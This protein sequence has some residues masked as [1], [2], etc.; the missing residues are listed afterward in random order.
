MANYNFKD[1]LTLGNEGEKIVIENLLSMGGKLVTTNNDNKY[2]AIIN[3]KGKDISYEI[4]TDVYCIPINDTGNMFVE[5]ECRGKSSGIMV[6]EAKWFVTYYKYLNQIWYIKTNDLMKLIT[7]NQTSIKR[8]AG[9]GDKG[10]N[11]KGFLINRKQ[12]K[13]SFIVVEL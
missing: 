2:D 5:F 13:K 8:T 12:F 10:S 1:D 6:T 3:R 4:K 9:S 11:T 7:D